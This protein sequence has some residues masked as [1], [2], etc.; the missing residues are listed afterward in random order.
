MGLNKKVIRL[1]KNYQATK[2]L[3]IGSGRCKHYPSCSNYALGCFEKFNFIKASFL[4]IF[5]IIRCTPLTKKIYDPV[6]LTRKEKKALKNK[7]IGLE[8]IIPDLVDFSNK[9]PY[10]L[11]IDYICYIYDNSKNKE[12]FYDYLYIFKMAVK[13]KNIPLNYKE[14]YP[15]IN[16]YLMKDYHQPEHSDIFKLKCD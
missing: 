7:Y 4:T 1:I 2:D 11:P 16:D 14:V 13:K 5:R 3:T 6:P 10:A 8:M 12:L 9:H 15:I